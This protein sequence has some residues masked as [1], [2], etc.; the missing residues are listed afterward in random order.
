MGKGEVKTNKLQIDLKKAMKEKLE[1]IGKIVASDIAANAPIGYTNVYAE[2]WDHTITDNGE[3]VTIHNDGREKYLTHLLEFGHVIKNKEGGP[4][5]GYSPP[6]EHIRPAYFR[7]KIKFKEMM[8]DAA[9]ESINES[10][11]TLKN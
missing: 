3:S 6:K 8:K 4:T 11:K 5:I 10:K 9:K 7:G 1:N 2:G